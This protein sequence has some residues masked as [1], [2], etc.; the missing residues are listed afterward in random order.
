[1]VEDIHV[2]Q[3]ILHTME[4]LIVISFYITGIRKDV[5]KGIVKK[6]RDEVPKK[7]QEKHQVW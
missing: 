1:M 4:I 2:F 7:L 3:I 5:S 6:N